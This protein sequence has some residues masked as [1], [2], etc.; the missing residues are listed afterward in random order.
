[1]KSELASDKKDG[2]PTGAVSLGHSLRNGS[3]L[4]HLLILGVCAGFFLLT[5]GFD[6]VPLPLRRGLAPQTFPQGVALLCGVLTLASLMA[7]LAKAGSKSSPLP[8]AFWI[9]I[10]VIPVFWL[11]AA[12]VDILIAMAAFIAFVCWLWGERRA[13]VLLACSVL[14]PAITFWLFS[15]LL[16]VRFPRGLL[17]NFIYG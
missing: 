13:F 2:A 12:F 14:T 10:S 9:S 11:V 6:P 3:I 5:L 1:M 7:T 4:M 15:D 8:P 17:V 16:E